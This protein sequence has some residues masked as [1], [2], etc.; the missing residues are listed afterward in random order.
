[1]V[2]R[3]VK[4]ETDREALIQFLGARKLPFT[5]DIIKGKRRS[6]EQNRL[7]RLWMNEISEQMGDRTPEEVRAYCKLT[8]GVPILRAENTRFCEMYDR[9]IKP[10]PYEQKLSIM[11]EPFDLA[12]TRL[13]TTVQKKAYLDEIQR[14]FSQQ[15]IVLTDPDARGRAA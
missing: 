12:V 4:D 8:I 15:G 1:M 13:M 5:A 6:T 7:Q 10:M 14:H 11:A 2:T 9:V 3:V